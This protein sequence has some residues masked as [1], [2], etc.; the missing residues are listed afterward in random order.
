MIG[1]PYNR[2]NHNCTHEVGEWYILNGYPD[3]TPISNGVEFERSFIL[4]MRRKF[5]KIES[6]E[7]AALILMKVKMT[8]DLHIGVWDQGMVHHCHDSLDGSGGQTIR[9]PLSILKR[10]YKNITYWRFKV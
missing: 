3:T 5:I 7:Q 8:N 1:T 2:L 10:D 4:W 9:S 6:L